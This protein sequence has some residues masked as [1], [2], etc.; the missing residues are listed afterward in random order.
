MRN[1]TA[2]D[3]GESSDRRLQR[4][5]NSMAD[6]TRGA[7]V[8]GEGDATERAGGVEGFGVAAFLAGVLRGMTLVYETLKHTPHHKELFKSAGKG[9]EGRCCS[10]RD[11]FA[12]S[13]CL[14]HRSRPRRGGMGAG[15]PRRVDVCIAQHVAKRLF[16]QH[17]DRHGRG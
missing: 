5:G 7:D 4:S 9:A 12:D 14:F 16:Q 13:Q 6:G 3:G 17:A 1:S 15:Q 10:F 8:D 2:W 11:D